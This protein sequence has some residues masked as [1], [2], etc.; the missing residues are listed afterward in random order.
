MEPSTKDRITETALQLFS[1]KGYLGTSL[2]DIAKQ[3]GV[4]K[5]A[6]YKHFACKQDILDCIVARMD[7]L[8]TERSQRFSMP[9]NELG[10]TAAYKEIPAE[11]IRAYSRAQFLHWTEEE[12]PSRFRKMLTLEQYR[13]SGMAELYQKYLA[14]GPVEY[15]ASV[16]G[17]ITGSED[18]AWQL[19][20]EFYGPIFLLYGLSDG[21]MSEARAME[22]LD[23]HVSRFIDQ[24]EA[25][26]ICCAAGKE[27]SR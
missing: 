7:E 15:M 18:A 13:D 20:L 3:V 2:G 19:S 16:F 23:D 14:D 26:R 4:S 6:L 17:E 22:L 25:G 5:A 8:D 24:M 21:G 10:G 27:D 1:E 12:F 9:G 11:K